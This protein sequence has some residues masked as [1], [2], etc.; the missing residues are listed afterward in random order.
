[1]LNLKKQLSQ[2]SVAG[3]KQRAQ[4]SSVVSLFNRIFD[5]P[6][7]WYKER[8]IAKNNYELGVKQFRLGNMHDAIFRF[9]IATWINPK[10]AFSWYWL[11]RSY[12]RDGK[13][14]EA[15][16]ALKKAVSLKQ[17]DEHIDYMLA[18]AQ[19]KTTSL[20]HIPLDLLKE[21]FERMAPGYNATVKAEERSEA[22]QVA[23]AARQAAQQG[24]IDHVILDLGAGT[25][26]CGGKLRDIAAQ[27]TGVDFCPAMLQQAKALQSEDG[28]KIYD[29]LIEREAMDFL[30]GVADSGFDMVLA[31][32]FVQYAGNLEPLF[33]QVARVLK[34][35]GIF[36]MSA[37]A[38]EKDFVFDAEK[39]T[40]TYARDYLESTAARV[41]LKTAHLAETNFA[42]GQKGWIGAF[43]K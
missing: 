42:P 30:Q 31:S 16:N 36:V 4:A 10:H 33:A 35:G 18:L 7:D 6:A 19:G 21:Y 23:S 22:A 39:E 24:R 28:K 11:G 43:T 40:F 29:A 20:Q 32:G 12:L 34:S 13:K 9:R 38:G 37:L 14:A 3:K 5:L 1:M 25:G 41:G 17:G 15:E 26:L 2:F 27:L 8:D